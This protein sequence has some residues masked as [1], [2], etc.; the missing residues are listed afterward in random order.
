MRCVRA[1]AMIRA[2]ASATRALLRGL[3]IVL[4][5]SGCAVGPDFKAPAVPTTDG[6]TAEKLPAAT[7]ATDVP[8]GEAQQFQFGRD[9]PGQWWVLFGSTELNRLI[10]EAVARYPGIAAQQAAL[11]A[12]R[13]NVRAQQGMFFPQIAGDAGWS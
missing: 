9:L 1:D 8:G 10:E 13:E 7:Q 2:T 12:A 11:R 6:Y 4:V 5:L 3:P